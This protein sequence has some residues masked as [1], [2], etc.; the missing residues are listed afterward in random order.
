MANNKFV[1]TFLVFLAITLLSFSFIA[2][3]PGTAHAATFSSHPSSSM[4]HYA[5]PYIGVAKCNSPPGGWFEVFDLY[6]HEYCYGGGGSISVDIQYVQEIYT[7][8]NWGHFQYSSSSRIY[9]SYNQ[10]WYPSGY[11]TLIAI[12]LYE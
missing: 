6:G 10:A 8:N 11:P 3:T 4:V 12:W 9:F 5:T 7:G 2:A 1:K